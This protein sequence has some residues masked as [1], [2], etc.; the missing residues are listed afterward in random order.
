MNLARNRYHWR[1][2][3][4]GMKNGPAIFQ[5]VMVHVLQG[6]DCADVHIDDVILCSS[7]DKEKKLSWLTKTAMS[8]PCCIGYKGRSWLFRLVK[9][10]TLYV[11]LNSVGICWK[12]APVS[13]HEGKCWCLSVQQKQ[14]M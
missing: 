13:Q 9:R 8:V 11:R 1:A 12:I 3:P 6:L 10:I 7:C 5:R 2:I 14:T 4:M